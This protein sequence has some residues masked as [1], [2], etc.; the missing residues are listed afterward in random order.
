MADAGCGHE[1]LCRVE[2]LAGLSV[3]R[4]FDDFFIYQ[5]NLFVPR[6]SFLQER[7]HFQPIDFW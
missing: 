2:N 6:L 5:S 4:S 1:N 7:I 3:I